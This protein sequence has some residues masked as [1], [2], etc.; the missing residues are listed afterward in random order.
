MTGHLDDERRRALADRARERV[1]QSAEADDVALVSYEDRWPVPGT[2]A[3]RRARRRVLGWFAAAILLVGVFVAVFVAWPWRYDPATTGPDYEWF[4]PL[5]GMSLGGALLCLSFA[6][7]SYVKAFLPREVAVQQRHDD[8]SPVEDQETT[9]VI[10]SD[11]GK[12]AGLTRRSWFRRAAGAGFGAAG[13][14]GLVLAGGGLLRDPWDA[15]DA[16]ESL[17]HTSWAPR[18]GETVYLRRADT[19]PEE[20]ELVRDGDVAVGGVVSVVPFRESERD[21]PAQLREAIEKADHA[22]MLFRLRVS[23]EQDAPGRYA[24]FSRICTH[25]GCPVGSYE[26]REQRLLC[27]CHQSQFAIDDGARPV[28]GPAVRALP[29][30][31]VSVTDDGYFVADG[32]FTGPVGPA[33]WELD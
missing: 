23:P 7:I 12:R 22:A 32:D 24:A 27:P 2:R 3:E 20:V 31:P 15:P 10:L 13:V 19:G 6:I 30:L 9:A 1:R 17:W 11:A 26:S 5:A 16:P 28:F 25:M 8:P 4:T 18:G 33:F 21:D 29:E 14:G